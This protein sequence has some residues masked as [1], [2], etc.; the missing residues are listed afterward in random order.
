MI[1]LLLPVNIKASLSENNTE[2]EM[3]N[4]LKTGKQESITRI[5]NLYAPALMGIIFRIVKHRELAEDALQETFVKIWKSANQYQETK[6]RLFTWM[7]RLAKNTAIDLLKSKGQVRS[8]KNSDIDEMHMEVDSKN[9]HK[10]N[11]ETIGIKQLTEE[12]TVTQTLILN[13]VYFQGYSH[14]E[15]AQELNMPLGSVKTKIRMS[16]LALRKFFC[17]RLRFM[18]VSV[19]F[20][21]FSQPI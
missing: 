6:G 14:A 8:A 2:R 7:A 20:R 21:N 13:M 18:I 15:V 11:T 19:L 1:A 4:A 9:H 3:V 17:Q 5:Y 12:L 10:Y 16:I